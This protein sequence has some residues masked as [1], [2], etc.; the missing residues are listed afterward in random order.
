MFLHSTNVVTVW[1]ERHDLE[2][3]QRS[4]EYSEYYHGLCGKSLTTPVTLGIDFSRYPNGTSLYQFADANAGRRPSDAPE[5]VEIT[6]AYFELTPQP[7]GIPDLM[8]LE[9]MRHA[10]S[11]GIGSQRKLAL[12][13]HPIRGWVDLITDIAGREA[14]AGVFLHTWR[15]RSEED[16]FKITEHRRRKVNNVTEDITIEQH[17]RSSLKAI[18]AVSIFSE[19]CEFHRVPKYFPG[20]TWGT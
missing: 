12:I 19:H 10:V 2:A 17:F 4:T 13:G 5:V 1:D 7:E 9:G 16:R 8:K 18:G 6:F 3:F 20:D 11:Y 14:C 15:S